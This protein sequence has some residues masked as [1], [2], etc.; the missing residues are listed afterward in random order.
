MKHNLSEINQLLGEAP[1]IFICPVS[2]E[3][4][5]LSIARAIEKNNLSKS[6][7]LWNSD[8]LS[9]VKENVSTL[10]DI[11]GNI[12]EEIELRTDNPLVT[13][14]NLREK[15]LPVIENCTGLCLID[16]TSFTHEHLLI[17]IR[18]MIKFAP[19]KN[20]KL[21]YSGADD[22]STNHQGEDKWLSKGLSNIRTVLG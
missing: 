20:I 2:Y 15:V 21:A 17:L 6:L 9:S 13:A 22:Y 18:L 3:E 1:E 19:E 16:I 11:F 12:S 14:D 7:L 10:K 5:S 4:R 8:F